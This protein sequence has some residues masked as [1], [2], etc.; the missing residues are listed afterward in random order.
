MMLKRRHILFVLSMFLFVACAVAQPSE[1]RISRIEYI[2]MW[3]ET[4]IYNM[5]EYGIPASIT[6]AQGILESGDGNSALA[7]YANNHFGIKCHGWDGPG[8]YQDDDAK[9]ECFRKYYDASESYK[10]HSLFLTTRSRYSDLFKLKQTDYKGWAKGLKKA[11]YAT[12]PQY[13]HLLIKIIEDNKLYEYDKANK[14]KKHIPKREDDP[15]NELVVDLRREVKVHPNNI[16]FVVAKKGD[17]PTSLAVEFD[18]G[19]WQLKKYNDLEK[20]SRLDEGDIIYLQPKRNRAEKDFHTVQEGETMRDI[21]QKYGVKIK[22]LYRKNRMDKGTQPEP[23][24]KISLR[25]RI[26]RR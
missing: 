24:Q 7:R 15:R 16:K 9:D 13:A 26:K 19:V 1:R 22:K 8:Y 12:N 17:T 21:S 5:H 4:A 20:G 14:A 10:D 11:G 2:N 18:M 23:G 3:K 6:L 25:K